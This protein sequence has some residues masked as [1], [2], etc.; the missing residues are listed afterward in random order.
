MGLK[1]VTQNNIIV[2]LYML[3]LYILHLFPKYTLAD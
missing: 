1:R 2:N 3:D